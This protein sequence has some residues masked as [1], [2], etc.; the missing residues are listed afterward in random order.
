MIYE[1]PAKGQPLLPQMKL[2]EGA[3][4]KETEASQSF[5][6]QKKLTLGS[7]DGNLVGFP[8]IKPTKQEGIRSEV[9]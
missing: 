4:S 5:S 7:L 8:K 9:I 1:L 3:W 6:G 2:G